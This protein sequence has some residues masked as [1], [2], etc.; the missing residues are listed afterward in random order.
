MTIAVEA[1]D[2]FDHAAGLLRIKGRNAAENAHVKMGAY[3]TLDLELNR[4]FTL[5]KAEWDS[6]ALERVD[7][8]TNPTKRADFDVAAVV[9]QDGLAHVCLVTASMT[10]VRAKIDVQIPRKRRGHVGQHDKAVGRF[11]DAVLQALLRHV[12][13]EN[14]KAVV[15]ASPGFVKDAFLEYV[16]ATAVKTDNKVLLE[17]KSKFIAAH[18]SSGFKHALKELL[19]D[20][21]IQSKL[22]DTKAAEEVRALQTFYKTLQADPLRACYGEKHV[23]KAVEAQAVETLLISD[24]L[25]RKAPTL[26]ERKRFVALVDGVKE[27]GGEVRVFSSMHVSGE[28]LDN[29]TGVCAILR[30]PMQEL[31]EDSDGDS[32]DEDDDDDCDS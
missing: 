13:F 15:V 3:H 30:F 4:K 7:V 1:V 31:D 29:L 16:F 6:V 14:I 9:M 21:A 24:S 23:L 8:A 2:D 12:N 25:F 26:T 19:Q 11:H 27:F 32:D 20:P 28:Q 10:I 18:S 17:N 5:A 22:A